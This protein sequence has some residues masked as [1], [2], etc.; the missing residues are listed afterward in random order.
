M[1]IDQK[2]IDFDQ[3]IAPS[4][5]ASEL[6]TLIQAGRIPNAL[7]FMGNNGMGKEQAAFDF[8]KACNCRAESSRPCNRCLSCKKIDARM[9]PD[10]IQI[11][12]KDKKKIISISQIREMTLKISVKPH[13]A[14][15]RMVLILE[16]DLMNLQAQNALLKVLEEPPENTFFILTVTQVSP[17]LPTIRSRCRQIR[18]KPIGWQTLQ[19]HL[20]DHHGVDPRAAAIAAQTTG[21][22][23]KKA[24]R[25]LNLDPETGEGPGQDWVKRRSWIIHQLKDLVSAPNQ[26]L[27]GLE[28]SQKLSLDPDLVLDT[29]AIIRTLLRDL[30][31]FPYTPEKIVNLDFFD[32]IKDISSRYDDNTF[33]GW[34]KELH[35][36]EKRLA[37]NSSIRLTLDQFFLK[38]T[39]IGI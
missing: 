10:M 16:G 28:F 22:D 31:L 9:H 29:M 33:L 37:S 25:F 15:F 17:L 30:C 18:F 6:T 12:L 11:S 20:L 38:L 8:A 14:L 21:S 7:I 1:S 3:K 23:L 4:Q 13:E 5:T 34:T 36:T 26:I 32:I 24:M 27:K 19:Q 39:S 35:E 2:R